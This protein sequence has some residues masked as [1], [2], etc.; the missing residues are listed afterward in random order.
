MILS[1]FRKIMH[2]VPGMSNTE[3]QRSAYGLF[4]NL[5]ETLILCYFWSY[6]SVGF[7]L[8][9]IFWWCFEAFSLSFVEKRL[10]TNH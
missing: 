8:N 4:L 7:L 9:Y 3:K 2:C 1:R 10:K 6:R 5:L